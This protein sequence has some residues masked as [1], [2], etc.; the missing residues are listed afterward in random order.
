VAKRQKRR[1]SDNRA[2][3]IELDIDMEDTPMEKPKGHRTTCLN[4]CCGKRLEKAFLDGGYCR[5]CK[6]ILP[7]MLGS[8]QK[9]R[10]QLDD[11]RIFDWRKEE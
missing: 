10:S 8:M 6:A 1:D 3:F 7:Q 11:V 5:D 2:K 4:T 9:A